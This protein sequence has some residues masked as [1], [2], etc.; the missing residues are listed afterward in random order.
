MRKKDRSCYLWLQE[1][2][3]FA[4]WYGDSLTVHGDAPRLIRSSGCWVFCNADLKFSPHVCHQFLDFATGMG[5]HSWQYISRF[6]SVRNSR[7]R[8]SGGGRFCVL[9]VSA[10]QVVCDGPAPA[11]SNFSVIVMQ[12]GEVGALDLVD[13]EA[14]R[15]QC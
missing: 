10:L 5:A 15:L 1:C 7:T 9:D 14:L 2:W 3:R 4:V 12:L 13:D 6:Q 8:H 11:I